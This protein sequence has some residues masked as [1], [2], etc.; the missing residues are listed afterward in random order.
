MPWLSPPVVIPPE[1]VPAKAGSRSPAPTV[2]PAQAGIQPVPA[3]AGIQPV[4]AQAGIQFLY[5]FRREA[6]IS[7]TAVMAFWMWFSVL[8]GPIPN[9]TAP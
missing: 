6:A 9:R 2:I 3:Q 5:Y 8:K 4:P 7:L 1:P